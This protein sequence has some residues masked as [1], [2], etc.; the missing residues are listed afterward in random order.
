M[1]AEGIYGKKK[2]SRDEVVSLYKKASVDGGTYTF[3]NGNSIYACDIG[4]GNCTDYHSY[5]ISLSR[6]MKLPTRFHMGFSIPGRK[7]GKITGYH[8]WADFYIENEGWHP[9]D[10]SEADNSPGKEN[11]FFGTVCNNRLEMMVGRDFILEGYEQNPINL[12]IYPILE[13]NDEA[14]SAFIKKISYKNI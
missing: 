7:E 4:V 2:V 6:T 14:S 3:G 8:C 12:F 13:V 10:I 1:S 5:F 11:Y 9:I